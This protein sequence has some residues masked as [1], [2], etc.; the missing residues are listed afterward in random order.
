MKNFLRFEL[1]LALVALFASCKTPT[2][3]DLAKENLI[4][5]P[6][7]LT[8]TGS[9][10]ELTKSTVIYVQAENPE[11]ENIG[12]YLSGFL[13]PATGFDLDVK[14]KE[15]KPGS[16]IFLTLGGHSLGKEGYELEITADMIV[17]EASNPAGLFRGVQTLRQLLPARIESA[18]KQKGPWGIASGTI[19]DEPTYAFRGAMLDVSRHFFGVDDVKRYIDFLAAY[20]MNIL[21][22]HLAD[23]QGWRIEIKSWPNLTKIG[24]STQVGGGEGGFYTQEQYAE[25]VKYAQARYITVIPEIDMPGH[26]NAALASYPEL[27]SDNK[28]KELYTGTKVGFST[29]MTDKEITY[30]FIDDVIGELA[31]ITPGP[32]MHVGGDESHA[33]KKD[34][35][36]VFINKVQEIVAAHG[37]QMIGWADIAAAGLKDNSIAQFWQTEPVNALKA[38]K[39]NVKIIMSPAARIYMDI[40]Y[41]SL[42]PLGLHWAGYTEVDDAYDWNPAT[43]V[44]GISKEN[45]LGVE[46]ALWTETI[47]DMEDIE[48]MVFPR[49]PGYA[50]LGWSDATNNSWG[51]YKLRLKSFA[52]R[53][54]YM[55]INYYKSP[56]VW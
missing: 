12:Q 7:S 56:L 31:A 28:A 13:K 17:L 29:L 25:I 21:H 34:D 36:L 33:T 1:V 52:K 51:E 48:Y 10:F 53:F 38:V 40:Q 26:I 41:D 9:S 18:E 50:E 54:D 37:K 16:D 5:K 24:G 49:L 20:K 43:L 3:K 15:N 8:A 30:K 44:E 46:A 32:Y 14:E 2:P 19:K 42:C 45:I 4:P 27:N 11:L 55:G 47:E 23:D 35:Y 39:Q 22:L 6:S